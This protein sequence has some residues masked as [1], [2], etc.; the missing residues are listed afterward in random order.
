MTFDET[1]G[2]SRELNDFLQRGTRDFMPITD[3]EPL[4]SISDLVAEIK[5]AKNEFRSAIN[6]EL[7]GMAA[8][9]RANSTIAVGKV[10]G[11]RRSLRDEFTQLNGNEV[12]DTSVDGTK[13]D[14]KA[15]A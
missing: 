11:E 15:G 2:K 10:R 14:D 1:L 13:D 12:V 3:G 4:L 9:I 5:A 6:Q 7:K 8:D